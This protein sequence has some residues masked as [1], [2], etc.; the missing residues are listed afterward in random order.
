MNT[1]RIFVPIDR[2][3]ATAWFYSD[4]LGLR[5]VER[6]GDK[7]VFLSGEGQLVE[8]VSLLAPLLESRTYVRFHVHGLD[9]CLRYLVSQGHL[10]RESLAEPWSHR[11]QIEVSDPAGNIITLLDA[12]G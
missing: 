10:S 12:A 8:L 5:E 2:M 3:D 4:G 6:A 7:R 9:E 11:R 1:I